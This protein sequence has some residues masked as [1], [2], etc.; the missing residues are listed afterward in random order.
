MIIRL[1]FKTIASGRNCGLCWYCES[2]TCKALY[3]TEEDYFEIWCCEK[4]YK[5]HGR[6]RKHT[7][8][9]KSLKN[10]QIN[11]EKDASNPI[12]NEGTEVQNG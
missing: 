2:P 6:I 10:S 4:C 11:T 9:S 12:I 3:G 8:K 7:S 5:L 1:R